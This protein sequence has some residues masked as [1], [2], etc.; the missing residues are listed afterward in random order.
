MP[1]WSYLCSPQAPPGPGERPLGPEAAS[2]V[3]GLVSI[4]LGPEGL[5]SGGQSPG[6]PVSAP[7][8]ARGTGSGVG[9]HSC[10]GKA[11]GVL[12]SAVS[13]DCGSFEVLVGGEWIGFSRLYVPWTVGASD[14]CLQICGYIRSP[15]PLCEDGAERGSGT[16]TARTSL[17]SLPALVC[18][19]TNSAPLPSAFL[20]TL[21]VSVLIL[22][23]HVSRTTQHAV[24]RARRP[25]QRVLKAIRLAAC[26][27]T[28]SR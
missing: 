3:Q 27:G 23:H 15:L 10:V 9:P 17:L 4:N 6:V 18:F 11:G 2:V 25:P 28:V 20:T 14:P 12:C 8:R 26:V 5:G 16:G 22:V 7:H 13:V 1:P 24:F 21:P 19:V